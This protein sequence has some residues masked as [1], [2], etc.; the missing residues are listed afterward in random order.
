MST[1]VC[2]VGFRFVTCYMKWDLLPIRWFQTGA[3][4][5]VRTPW[6]NLQ[7]NW[8]ICILSSIVVSHKMTTSQEEH[9]RRQCFVSCSCSFLQN[10]QKKQQMSVSKAEAIATVL[11]YLGHNYPKDCR[12]CRP[13]TKILQHFNFLKEKI[14]NF[15]NF[16]NIYWSTGS[17]LNVL[18]LDFIQ[19]TFFIKAYSFLLL[20]NMMLIQ[21]NILLS[22][23]YSGFLIAQ[24][25]RQQKVKPPVLVLGIQKSILWELWPVYSASMK[26]V[27][28]CFQRIR[29]VCVFWFCDSS[30]V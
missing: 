21:S 2:T 15:A 29:L 30:R 25:V 13:R 17:L 5:Q 19:C 10:S 4:P 22:Y 27:E 11:T 23:S 3:E 26:M 12:C 18:W 28:S 20:K 8:S 16:L 24:N 9:V 7:L 6:P 14:I 1:S